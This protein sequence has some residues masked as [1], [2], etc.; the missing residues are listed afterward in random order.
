M[1]LSAERGTPV[2][3]FSAAHAFFLRAEHSPNSVATND[4]E[5]KAQPDHVEPSLNPASAVG[6]RLKVILSSQV[7]LTNIKKTAR[8]VTSSQPMIRRPNQR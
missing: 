4:T 7:V 8:T 5:M 1:A 6:H 2:A 3:P